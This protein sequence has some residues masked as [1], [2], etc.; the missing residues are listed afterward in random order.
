[1]LKHRLLTFLLIGTVLFFCGCEVADSKLETNLLYEWEITTDSDYQKLFENILDNR[2]LYLKYKEDNTL[3][4]TLTAVSQAYYEKKPKYTGYTTG[5]LNNNNYTGTTTIYE[6]PDREF[7]Y[8][9]NYDKGG[10]SIILID[11]TLINSQKIT[12]LYKDKQKNWKENIYNLLTKIKTS[13]QEDSYDTT[14][15][16]IIGSNIIFKDKDKNFILN[17][18]FLENVQGDRYKVVD[19][20]LINENTV[21]I[22]FSYKITKYDPYIQLVLFDF[23]SNDNLNFKWTFNDKQLLRPLNANEITHLEDMPSKK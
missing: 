10:I 8:Y 18:V 6:K 5:Y 14:D 15:F 2:T 12:Q 21:S 13:K 4:N 1:M 3:M 7:V 17:N 9:K 22:S 20:K 19:F 23:L 11:K 16:Y